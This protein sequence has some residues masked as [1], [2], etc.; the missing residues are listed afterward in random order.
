MY[1]IIVTNQPLYVKEILME[2]KQVRAILTTAATADL[3]EKVK[4]ELQVPD[5]DP[6][7][8]EAFL[9]QQQEEYEKYGSGEG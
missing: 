8:A 4:A 2:S 6:E 9:R 7:T 1:N 5:P 3:S